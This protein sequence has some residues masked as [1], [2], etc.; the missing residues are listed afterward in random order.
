[1]F[2]KSIWPVL[3]RIAPIV[4]SNIDK[5]EGGFPIDLPIIAIFLAST[6]C[7]VKLAL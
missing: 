7:L 6:F 3:G 4:L 2:Y 5:L 1:M